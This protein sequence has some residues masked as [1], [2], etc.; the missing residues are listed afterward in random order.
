MSC[1]AQ[2]CRR[3]DARH[4]PLIGRPQRLTTFDQAAPG[5]MRQDRER[6]IQL[7]S[8]TGEEALCET[9]CG[10]TCMS[11]AVCHDDHPRSRH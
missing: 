3:A 2:Q 6:A 1:A 8:V 5:F 10:L 9:G 7:G 11:R 4:D